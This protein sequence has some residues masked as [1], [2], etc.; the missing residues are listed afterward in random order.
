MPNLGLTNIEAANVSGGEFR[1]LPAGAYEC[2]IVDVMHEPEQQ[3]VWFVIDVADGEYAGYYSDAY[4]IQ[5]PNSHR[6]LLSYR[7]TGDAERDARIYGMLKGRLQVIDEC[8]PGFDA[9]AAFEADKWELFNSRKLGLVV[10]E[11]QYTS[12]SGELR[13]RP[14]WFHARWRNLEA[15]RSGKCKIP[16]LLDENGQKVIEQPQMPAVPERGASVHVYDD[17]IPFD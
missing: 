15:V 7:S 12:N 3:R 14:D 5:H 13:T 2:K 17:D 10:G 4:G 8:N 11:Q 1:K 16:E 9:V 6:L